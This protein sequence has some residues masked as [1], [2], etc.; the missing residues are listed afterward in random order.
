MLRSKGLRL[1][2]AVLAILVATS[3]F[4]ESRHL[5]GTRGSSGH[6]WSGHSSSSSHSF[7]GRSGS[8]RSYAPS[9]SYSP[10]RGTSR[11]RSV[12]PSYRA[13][14]YRGGSSYRAPAYRGGSS[15]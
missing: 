12:A 5:G 6:S 4:A 15:Y 13:P 10:S 1:Q 8:S 7:F 14:A 9:R 3:A 2:I 11:G